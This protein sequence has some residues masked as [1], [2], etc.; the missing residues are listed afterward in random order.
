MA[1]EALLAFLLFS[2]FTSYGPYTHVTY[3]QLLNHRG[4]AIFAVLFPVFG[5]GLGLY[6]REN[7]FNRLLSF[8][9]I[10]LNW[11]IVTPLTLFALYLFTYDKIGRWS[12]GLGSM[13][14]TLAI[15]FCVH[16][17]GA[18]LLKVY[19]HRFLYLG[20]RSKVGDL[21]FQELAWEGFR[22]YQHAGELEPLFIAPP[23]TL[24][25][26]ELVKTFRAHSV[27]EVVVS[28]EERVDTRFSNL[29]FAC[30]R[31]GIRVVED[32]EYF[33][34]IARRIPVEGLPPAYVLKMGFDIHRPLHA[35][36]KRLTDMSVAIL[37]IIVLFPLL[38]LIALAVR[39]ESK[40]PALYRQKR[41]GRFD[42]EF[43]LLKFRT[44]VWDTSDKKYY[45]E[46]DDKR[47]TSLG[48][49]LR[50]THL[51]EL[52]QLWNILIGQMALV[53][54]RPQPVQMV[55]DVS[56]AVPLF[57]LRHMRRPGLTG[58]AQLSQ[59]KTAVDPNE[60]F[61]KLSYDLYYIKHFNIALDF[62]ILSRTAFRLLRRTW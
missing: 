32:P 12:L 34:E 38:I 50:A 7:R 54:P 15:Y 16:W 59:G 6:D 14:A 8:Q 49:F 4:G 23:S 60:I 39:L 61:E 58:L 53:G 56:T 36:L 11:I 27:S 19:P 2:Y 30:L 37:L 44:M 20:K 17:F 31:Q 41:T 46:K 40:G 13:G 26:D 22:H 62:W 55:E 21:L 45:V 24:T 47:I 1:W 9:L 57:K 25:P 10:L 5:L 3:A 18:K 52:P 51:D 42:S 29:I 33:E 28:W 43:N 35:I 48:K